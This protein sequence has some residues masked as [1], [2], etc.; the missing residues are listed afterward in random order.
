MA[1]TSSEMCAGN[2]DAIV[3]LMRTPNLQILNAFDLFA[4]AKLVW[5]VLRPF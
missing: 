5:V 2:T 4:L 1:E 3:I